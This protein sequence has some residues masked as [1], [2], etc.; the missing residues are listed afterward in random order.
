[1]MHKTCSIN[2]G[3]LADLQKTFPTTDLNKKNFHLI[4]YLLTTFIFFLSFQSVL[5]IPQNSPDSIIWNLD[6]NSSKPSQAFGCILFGAECHNLLI[7]ITNNHT[8]YEVYMAYSFTHI[9]G[10]LL[11]SD[12][13]SNNVLALML[14]IRFTL[15]SRA[16]VGFWL[17]SSLDIFG[18]WFSD[19]DK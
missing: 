17:T 3:H 1:M 13:V 19:L 12:L 15:P 6:G 5:V 14:H 7:N 8:V 11:S 18:K 9:P 16:N 2:Y 10:M 4:K